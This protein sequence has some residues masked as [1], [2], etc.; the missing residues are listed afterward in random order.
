M[1]LDALWDA[2]RQVRTDDARFERNLAR[3]LDGVA[4]G[5]ER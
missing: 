4:A 1:G 2:L 3:L 5:L